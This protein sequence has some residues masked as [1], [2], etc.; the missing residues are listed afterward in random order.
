M[1]IFVLM[2]SDG[3]PTFII[4][5]DG[6]KNHFV[7]GLGRKVLEIEW[8]GTQDAAKVL[9]TIVEVDFEDPHNRFNDAKADPRGR[10]FAG[11]NLSNISCCSII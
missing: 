10:L 3:M 1:S 2:F 4:P 6:K 8:D 9:R 7:V 5:V 11:E